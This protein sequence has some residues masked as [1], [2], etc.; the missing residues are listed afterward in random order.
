MRPRSTMLQSTSGS[1]IWRRVSRTTA[2]FSE[3]VVRAVMSG[4]AG[5]GGD[6]DGDGRARQ[7]GE[8]GPGEMGEHSGQIDGDGHQAGQEDEGAAAHPGGVAEGGGHTGQ[9]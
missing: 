1:M 9:R 2:S 7:G 5:W 6:G 3:A 8:P 4:E